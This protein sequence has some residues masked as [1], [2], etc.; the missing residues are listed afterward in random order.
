[1]KKLFLFPFFAILIASAGA[2]TIKFTEPTA[3]RIEAGILDK[4]D[5]WLVGETDSSFEIIM[6][7]NETLCI[8]NGWIGSVW[9]FNI[10]QLLDSLAKTDGPAITISYFS[11]GTENQPGWCIFSG[12]IST[13]KTQKPTPS[14][15]VE[16][17]NV[18]GGKS[19]PG[20]NLD[21]FASSPLGKGWN[22]N[23]FGL[24]SPSWGEILILPSKGFTIDDSYVEISAG[25][26]FETNKEKPV[27][28][29]GSVFFKDDTGGLYGDGAEWLLFAERGT[30]DPNNY[31]YLGYLLNKE[32]WDGL[33]GL[34]TFSLGFHAQKDAVW[35]VRGQGEFEKIPLTVWTAFG[36][37][38]EMGRPGAVIGIRYT[39]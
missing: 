22:L 9:E 7:D 30:S 34:R 14:W 5:G 35:G 15:W 33:V 13:P 12:E 26:G 28:F 4:D 39:P 38:V 3:I 20:F 27:R 11:S 25:V 18:F 31:W 21:F 37:N 1:M 36:W 19:K 8:N 2:Q 10:E 29:G 16:S 23:A 6:Y 17:Q 24:V 32:S